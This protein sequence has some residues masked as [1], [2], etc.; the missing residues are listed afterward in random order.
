MDVEVG[1]LA[2][3]WQKDGREVEWVT[4]SED[5][6]LITTIFCS[7]S[8]SGLG[9]SSLK[10]EG[11]IKQNL[12]DNQRMMANRMVQ[13]KN[14]KAYKRLYENAS[15]EKNLKRTYEGNP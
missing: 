4:D 6:G 7:T 14:S 12:A 13:R 11:I 5:R 9:S 10:D 3:P 1:K 15:I 2:C 8:S